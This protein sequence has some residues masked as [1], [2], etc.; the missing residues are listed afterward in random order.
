MIN[1]FEILY[2]TIILSSYI[3]AK[4]L[5]GHLLTSENWAFL[6]RFCFLS[7]E[8]KFHYNFLVGG[9]ESNVN[10]LLYYD[11]AQQWPSVYPSEKTCYEKQSILSRKYGQIVT[12][13]SR[14]DLAISSGCSRVND[15]TSDLY[16]TSSREFRSARPRWWFIVLADCSSQNGLN[17]SYWISLTN[18]SPGSFWREHFSA[19]E[20]Y[21]L[22]ELL[23][24][25]VVYTVL[26][27]L[28]FYVSLQ[29][30]SRRL[31]HLS[32]KI[33]IAS[34]LCQ[35]LGLSLET[36]SYV[37]RALT[38]VDARQSSLMGNLLEACAETLYTVLMLLLA[39]GYTVTKSILTPV[40]TK[41]LVCFICTS[42]IFQLSLFIY[43]SEMFDP[44]LV[45]YIYESPPGY[46]LIAIKIITWMVF[47]V[48]CYK[49]SRKTTTKIRFYIALLSM[50]SGWFLWNP[51]LVLT[52][53]IMVDK[54]IRES[55]VKGCSLWMIL[56]GHAIFLYVT[57]PATNNTRFPFH[58]RTCQVMPI[59]GDGE[60]H[61]YQPRTQPAMTLFTVMH[62]NSTLPNTSN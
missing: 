42:V 38:G 59:A 29:L 33:F 15:N 46:A 58:I 12:L 23:A 13:S 3:D 51:L 22:P 8:G 34:L 10:L 61:S 54:W 16:C 6:T 40:E 14:S 56:V 35:M 9:K 1:M 37:S 21:I 20:F 45:L 32:Y 19:D 4:I 50:G 11:T 55:V 5:Q 31:F 26:L 53:T 44:G 48:C 7:E 43:Q 39:L 24:G 17:V 52:I 36:L 30:R 27:V 47:V 60:S 62:T 28:S 2:A 57:R 41:Q 18:G 49:T 25:I